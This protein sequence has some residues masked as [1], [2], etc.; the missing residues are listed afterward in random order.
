MRGRPK[1]QNIPGVAMPHE[2]GCW[3]LVRLRAGPDWPPYTNCG[4]RALPGLLRCVRHQ[5]REAAARELR[6][7]LDLDVEVIRR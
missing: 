3:A 2:G 1:K 5:D 6:P 4:N 7:E